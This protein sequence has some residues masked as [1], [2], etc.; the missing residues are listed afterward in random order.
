MPLE[1]TDQQHNI[2]GTHFL[3]GRIN[4]LWALT[5]EQYLSLSPE[6]RIQ[7]SWLQ[8]VQ[9]ISNQTAPVIVTVDIDAPLQLQGLQSGS[10]TISVHTGQY[11][12]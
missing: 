9:L 2:S 10:T 7:K 1:A 4:K 8:A 3:K 5:Q 12:V 6:R 11:T